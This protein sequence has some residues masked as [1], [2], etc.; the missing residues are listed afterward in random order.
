MAPL[1]RTRVG[2]KMRA[3]AK[4]CVDYAGPFA[5]KITRRVSAKKVFVPVYVLI[6][7]SGAFRNGMFIEHHRF[8]ECVQPNG[9]HQGKTGRSYK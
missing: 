7:Q 6:N 4:C 8:P 5:T 2:T 1:P 3:F 9:S